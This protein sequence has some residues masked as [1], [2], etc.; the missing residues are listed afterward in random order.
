MP[1]RPH[2]VVEMSPPKNP[3]LRDRGFRGGNE[4]A[5]YWYRRMT[6]ETALQTGRHCKRGICGKGT[7]FVHAQLCT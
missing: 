6:S 1:V 7:L 4:R 3:L 5:F 2:S